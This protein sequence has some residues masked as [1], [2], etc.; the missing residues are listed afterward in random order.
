MIEV[1]LDCK[2]SGA[3]CSLSAKGHAGFAKKGKDI[4]CAAVSSLLR[5]T[6]KVLEETGGIQLSETNFSERGNLAFCVHQT[7]S[8]D[9]VTE[10]LKCTA[11]FVRNGLILLQNEYPEH[12][13]LRELKN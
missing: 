1:L 7:D 6:A 2:S 3:I 5:T 13:I 8:S 9:L 11:S 4:V 12:L 10:R